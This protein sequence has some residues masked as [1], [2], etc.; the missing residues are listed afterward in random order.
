MLL[1]AVTV[2]QSNFTQTLINAGEHGPFVLVGQSLG[3]LYVMRFK[4]YFRPEVVGLVLVD[5]FH[6]SRS[7][8]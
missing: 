2:W 1:Q 8:A 7:S 6:P 5:P 3:G 4:R